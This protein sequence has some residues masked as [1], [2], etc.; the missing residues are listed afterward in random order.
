MSR[1]GQRNKKELWGP[2]GITKNCKELFDNTIDEKWTYILK[3]VILLT[4]TTAA[5]NE[6]A[7]SYHKVRGLYF[8]AVVFVGSII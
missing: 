8:L 6:D 7:L 3:G 4:K 2:K 1:R 5:Q